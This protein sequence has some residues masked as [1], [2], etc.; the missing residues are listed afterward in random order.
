VSAK[1]YRYTGKERDEETGLGYHGARYYA[2]WLG[3]WTAADPIGLGDGVNRF[4]YVNGNP[5]RLIDPRGTEGEEQSKKA[6]LIP[7]GQVTVGK[8]ENSS[9]AIARG[10]SEGFTGLDKSEAASLARYLG[11]TGQSGRRVKEGDTIALGFT[12]ELLDF[13]KAEFDA[14]PIERSEDRIAPDLIK[15][16]G[17]GGYSKNVEKAAEIA[18]IGLTVVEVGLIAFGIGSIV[19]GGV[20]LAAER[21]LVKGAEKGL[22]AGETR[23]ISA[24][25][26][27]GGRSSVGTRAAVEGGTSHSATG[28]GG[29]IGL[30]NNALVNAIEG[31]G[32]AVT[33]MAGRTPVVSPTAARE[34]LRGSGTQRAALGTGGARSANAAT[35]REFLQRF[36]G[37]LGASS[38]PAGRAAAE[39]AGA[40]QTSRNIKAKSAGDPGV[41]SSTIEDGLNLLTRDKNLLKKFSFTEL[42]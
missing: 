6:D 3:R 14:S 15:G 12:P 31:S 27:L 10:L 37:R 19:S 17:A 35:L 9:A 36:G 28:G 34:F 25:A 2:P 26:R 18:A 40:R 39:A 24:T 38:T 1:R 7:V 22:I 4:S 13:A 11:V 29:E 8:G 23:A 32:E 42:F 20:K 41:I 16:K 21:A 33:A 30:D 5:V